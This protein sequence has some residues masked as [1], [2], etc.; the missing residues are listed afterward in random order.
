MRFTGGGGAAAVEI[1]CWEKIRNKIT[2]SAAAVISS[3]AYRRVQHVLFDIVV[4]E[5]VSLPCPSVSIAAAPNAFHGFLIGTVFRSYDCCTVARSCRWPSPRGHAP[6]AS[7]E[8]RTRREKGRNALNFIYV[9][10]TVAFRSQARIVYARAFRGKIKL[11]RR[12]LSHVCATVA[13][14]AVMVDRLTARFRAIKH[15]TAEQSRPNQ[16]HFSHEPRIRSLRHRPL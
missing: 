9:F 13:V 1:R 16:C 8:M 12:S 15:V 5:R 11:R 4:Y 3:V 14:V 6:S 7:R 2:R 10:R